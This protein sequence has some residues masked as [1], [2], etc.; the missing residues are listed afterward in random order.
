MKLMELAKKL[1]FKEGDKVVRAASKGDKPHTIKYN[2]STD[3]L[4]HK[5]KYPYVLVL[6]SGLEEVYSED[7]LRPA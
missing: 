6:D 7:E 3:P 1:K 2:K 5:D 4:Y